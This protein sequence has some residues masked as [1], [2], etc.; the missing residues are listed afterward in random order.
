MRTKTLALLLCAAAA[1]STAPPAAPTRPAQQDD[2]IVSCDQQVDNAIIANNAANATANGIEKDLSGLSGGVLG[3]GFGTPSDVAAV[4]Q[5]VKQFYDKNSVSYTP[6]KTRFA[7]PISFPIFQPNAISVSATYKKKLT[8]ARSYG[9]ADPGLGNYAEPDSRYRLAS[10]SK[11]FTGMAIMKLVHDGLLSLDYQPFN[12]SDFINQQLGGYWNNGGWDPSK[13][14]QVSST[15]FYLANGCGGINPTLKKITVRDLLHHAGGWDRYMP[16]IG[17]PFNLAWPPSVINNVPG[18]STPPTCADTIRFFLDQPVQHEPGTQSAYSNLGFC[19][20]GEVVAFASGSTYVDYV[21]NH[22]L[23]PLDMTETEEGHTLQN[24]VLDREVTYFE[25][26]PNIAGLQPSVFGGG[27]EPPP[28]GGSVYLEPAH[29]SGAWVS[30]TLDLAH[31]LSSIEQLSLKNFPATSTDPNWPGEFATLTE[32]EESYDSNNFITN[33]YPPPLGCLTEIVPA[34]TWFGAGWDEISP[35][36][37][38]TPQAY[39]WAKNGGLS[40]TSTEVTIHGDDDWTVTVLTNGSPPDYCSQDPNCVVPISTESL[41]WNIW[42]YIWNQTTNYFPQYGDAVYSDW[43]SQTDF[44]NAV[45]TGNGGLGQ[46]PSRVDGQ[47]VVVSTRYPYCNPTLAME[48]Q[49]PPPIIT[50]APQYR[51]RWGAAPASGVPLVK[52]NLD[53]TAM[54]SELQSSANGQLVSL[55]KFFDYGSGVWRYQAVFSAP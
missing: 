52:T 47:Q 55:Q 5:L 53:C 10:V 8:L 16:G 46:Y 13:C 7:K 9:Y 18:T 41:A 4:D 35:V 34:T 6:P 19:I 17:D 30:S 32:E 45:S 29:A 14:D 15:V 31:F 51:A 42:S 54:K 40:G 44:D 20:L 25:S 11:T 21:N 27:L 1:C 36:G 12:H 22:V 2:A 28:Y 37:S 33:C 23:A 49:C 43:Q 48:D 38:A 26:D 39:Y 50:Y 3:F 24:D